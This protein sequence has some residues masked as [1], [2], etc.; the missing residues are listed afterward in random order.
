MLLITTILLFLVT[1]HSA[2]PPCPHP[3]FVAKHI[4]TKAGVSGAITCAKAAENVRKAEKGAPTKVNHIF[5][6]PN[7]RSSMTYNYV[8]G[9]CVFN[10]KVEAYKC[11]KLKGKN[12][13]WNCTT[14]GMKT[15]SHRADNGHLNL[16][17][18]NYYNG[19]DY[20]DDDSWECIHLSH[21]HGRAFNEKD[22]LRGRGQ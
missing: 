4:C 8:K 15:A 13:S 17:S 5:M 11:T 6:L 3:L 22:K 20:D 16:S 2:P 10:T 14:L 1:V 21:S 12:G 19:R 9:Q 7:G 18:V